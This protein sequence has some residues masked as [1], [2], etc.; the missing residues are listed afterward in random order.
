MDKQKTEEQK[1]KILDLLKEFCTKK[2][3]GEYFEL[4][5]RLIQKLARKRNV[6]FATG[7]PKIWAAAIIHTLG[8]INFL[9]D[10]SFEPYLSV[11]DINNFFGANKST[12]RNKSRQIRNLL[13][14]EPWDNEFSTQN[15]Q[16][17]NPFANLVMVDG[18][19]VPLDTLPEQYQQ[20]VREARAQG[21]D[22]SFTTQ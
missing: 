7:Q 12:I 4:A 16:E 13:K 22:I 10:K 15:M 14:L 17:S 5:E 11:D 3:D 19:I 2:L 9:F 18:L 20:A 8:T 6:P 21:K 1:Q